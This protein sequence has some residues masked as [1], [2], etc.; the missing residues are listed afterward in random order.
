M[1]DYLKSGFGS[2]SAPEGLVKSMAIQSLMALEYLHSKRITHRD[3]KPDN[4]LVVSRKPFVVKLADFGLSKIS[5]Q[6]K[7]MLQ[8]FCGTIYYCAPEVYADYD[9]YTNVDAVE[10]DLKKGGYVS[11]V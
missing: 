8:T 5:E 3:I 11:A 4:I 1:A 6:D 2:R 7:T 10:R 9:S